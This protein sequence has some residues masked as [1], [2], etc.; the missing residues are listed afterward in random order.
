M[1]SFKLQMFELLFQACDP[2]IYKKIGTS[3]PMK[4]MF[5]I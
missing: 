1:N 2:Y 4:W 3:F 5:T